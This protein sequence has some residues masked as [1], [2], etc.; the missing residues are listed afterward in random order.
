MEFAGGDVLPAPGAELFRCDHRVCSGAFDAPGEQGIDDLVVVQF[1]GCAGS[2][3]FGEHRYP[4]FLCVS[5]DF[6]ALPFRLR[7]RRL[8]H[9]VKLSK[10][11][12]DVLSGAKW[13]GAGNMD[14]ISTV[15]R[16]P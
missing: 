10:N 8:R 1:D 5:G 4:H 2:G 11:R 16:P 6:A 15:G 9:V 12:A 3:V 7:L 13:T 14:C